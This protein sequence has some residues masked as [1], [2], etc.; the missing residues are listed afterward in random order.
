MFERKN[1]QDQPG[2]ETA[3]AKA[4][5]YKRKMR[6]RRGHRGH[7]RTQSSTASDFNL[8]VALE[9]PKEDPRIMDRLILEHKLMDGCTTQEAM[10]KQASTQ[11]QAAME[12]DREVIIDVL[13][14]LPHEQV[15]SGFFKFGGSKFGAAVGVGE[16][17]GSGM[18]QIVEIDDE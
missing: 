14:E 16:V 3:A 13:D 12:G 9:K 18:E 17:G 10:E 1:Y 11:A 2:P 6:Q 8:L 7:R 4:A 15:E 5:A